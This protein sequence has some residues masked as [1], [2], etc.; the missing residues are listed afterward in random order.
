MGNMTVEVPGGS[1]TVNVIGLEP[2][3]PRRVTVFHDGRKLVGSAWVTGNESDPADGQ[4]SDPGGR[5]S[6]GSC[7][8]RGSRGRRGRST[9]AT[10]RRGRSS[11]RSAS[12]PAPARR[13]IKVGKDGRFQIDGLVPGLKYA[14]SAT[15][16]EVILGD[17][18]KDVTVAPGEVKDLGDLKVTPYKP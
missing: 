10:T 12:S 6:A 18:F 8:S 13:E 14:G 9:P 3:K 15:D 2:E 17:L 16:G 4:A 11:K 5:S 7:P 1:S